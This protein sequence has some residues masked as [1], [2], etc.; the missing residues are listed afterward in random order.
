MRNVRGVNTIKEIPIVI[1]LFRLSRVGE[2]VTLE[3]ELQKIYNSNIHVNIGWNGEG[4]D[5]SV[6]DRREVKGH[7]KT[8]AEI[9]PWLQRRIARHYPRSKYTVDRLAGKWKP[10]WIP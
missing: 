7:V 6:G 1:Q 3:K 10:I 2:E 9:L 4:I 5:V 8:V